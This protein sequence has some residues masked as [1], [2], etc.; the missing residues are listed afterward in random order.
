MSF[1]SSPY[2]LLLILR[3]F[4]VKKSSIEC[5]FIKKGIKIFIKN[6]KTKKLRIIHLTIS[7]RSSMV[8]SK[9][10]WIINKWNKKGFNIKKYYIIFKNSTIL[11]Y[12]FVNWPLLSP[13]KKRKVIVFLP[14]D[15]ANIKP[16]FFP[17]ILLSYVF[18]FLFFT[19][20]F[21]H[22]YFSNYS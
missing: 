21:S 1:F 10:F 13:L 9:I 8:L 11:R 2:L 16:P 4:L 14:L 20:F 3:F 6:Y 15:E 19:W 18:F 17:T 5:F 12:L 22:N 7:T